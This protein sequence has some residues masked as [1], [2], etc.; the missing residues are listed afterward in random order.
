MLCNPCDLSQARAM[1]SAL[2]NKLY[3]AVRAVFVGVLSTFLIHENPLLSG[4]WLEP[5][6]AL[7]HHCSGRSSTVLQ[8]PNPLRAPPTSSLAPYPIV[9]T[10]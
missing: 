8:G 2:V 10:A 3:C 6:T 1:R 7:A 5:F 9:T 4:L